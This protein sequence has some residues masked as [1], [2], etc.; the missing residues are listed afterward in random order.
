MVFFLFLGGYSLP[1]FFVQVSHRLPAALNFFQINLMGFLMS[2]NSGA[3][4][5]KEVHILRSVFASFQQKDNARTPLTH[6][7]NLANR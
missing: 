5:R 4:L 6:Y 3:A 1:P 7:I 2:L